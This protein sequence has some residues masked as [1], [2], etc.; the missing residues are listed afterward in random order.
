MMSTR[1]RPNHQPWLL[2]PT[3]MLKQIHLPIATPRAWKKSATRPLYTQ[4]A[5]SSKMRCRPLSVTS[6]WWPY[7]HQ[8]CVCV[9]LRVRVF[10][11]ACVC[12]CV[13]ARACAF[14]CVC[15]CVLVCVSVPGRST[16][17]LRRLQ[18]GG[19]GQHPRPRVALTRA[20]AAGRWQVALR[21]V[22]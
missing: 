22:P 6:A 1:R 9:C 19:G 11:C 8:S 2:R 14:V 7:T 16:L 13:C 4:P 15:L 10:A 3:K 12:V 5:K 20:W 17:P 18:A 21:L